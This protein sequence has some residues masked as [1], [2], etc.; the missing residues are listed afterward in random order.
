MQGG[1]GETNIKNRLVDLGRGE[2]RVRCAER[3]PRK[4]IL[5]YVK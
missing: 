4:L 5:S 2:E 1:S 3:V